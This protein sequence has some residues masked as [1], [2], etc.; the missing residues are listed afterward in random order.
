MVL[1]SVAKRLSLFCSYK[2]QF[3][4]CPWDCCYLLKGKLCSSSKRGTIQCTLGTSEYNQMDRVGWAGITK[5]IQQCDTVAECLIL[6]CCMFGLTFTISIISGIS[7]ALLG[8]E[9]SSPSG[10]DVCVRGLAGGG[11]DS[12]NGIECHD[13][14]FLSGCCQAFTV[15]GVVRK[16]RT[17]LLMPYRN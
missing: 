8:I 14:M 5:Q 13:A 9:A 3:L 4:R 16:P 6:R 2:V 1:Y 7:W 11:E 12:G 17:N 15:L 10:Q